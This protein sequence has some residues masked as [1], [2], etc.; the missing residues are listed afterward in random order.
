[1]AGVGVSRGV[2]AR[3]VRLYHLAEI[4]LLVL[5]IR[6]V[7]PMSRLTERVDKTLQ[8]LRDEVQ[9]IRDEMPKPSE[10]ATDEEIDAAFDKIDAA[11]SNASEGVKAA[12]GGGEAPA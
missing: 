3:A 8:V 5:I 11:I 9:Q 12:A 1:M 6:K 7:Y 4:V 10:G 2:D